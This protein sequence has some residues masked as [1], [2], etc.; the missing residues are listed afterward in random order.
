LVNDEPGSVLFSPEAAVGVSAQGRE[1]LY[2]YFATRVGDSRQEIG[3]AARFL[4]GSTED[5][6]RSEVVVYR[7]K[8]DVDVR[9]PCVVRW[10][11]YSMLFATQD[12]SPGSS[13]PVVV[14]GLAPADALLPVASPP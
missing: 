10:P 9:Q 8:A 2:L 1:I 11:D 3:M 6:E 5:L 12:A 13:A 14:A 4:D 7:P